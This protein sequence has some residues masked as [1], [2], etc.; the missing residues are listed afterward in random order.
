VES[1]LIIGNTCTG[2]S[3]L[4]MHLAR[5]FGGHYVSFGDLKRAA[6]ARSDAIGL[7]IEAAAQKKVAIVHELGMQLIAS[8]LG[9]PIS[10]FEFELFVTRCS[11]LGS[12]VV[13]ASPAEIE[14]RFF[15]RAVCPTC[16]ES[17]RAGDRCRIHDVSLTVRKDNTYEELRRRQELYQERI[18]AFVA[19]GKIQS[20]PR[21]N[22]NSESLDVT[23][24]ISEAEGW[25]RGLTRDPE[26]IQE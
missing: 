6:I 13:S 11:V 20:F 8:G 3:T 25:V 17:G 26:R 2:K 23:R 16:N 1:I 18:V 7:G 9:Y 21:L 15:G 5:L 14:R 10:D 12:I 24:L 19:T 22:L 4:G